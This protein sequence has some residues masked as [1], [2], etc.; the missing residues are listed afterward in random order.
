M[1]VA[2]HLS[3]FVSFLMAL[4]SLAVPAW[5]GPPEVTTLVS[6]RRV[7]AG[8]SFTLTLAISSDEPLRGVSGASFNAPTGVTASGPSTSTSTQTR[9]VNG[10]RSDR[11]SV[12]FTF[13]LTAQ[14]LGTITLP[15]PSAMHRGSRLVGQPT[16]IEVVPASGGSAGASG[17][18]LG[19]L[20]APVPGMMPQLFPP[21]APDF[22]D[23][24][25][26]DDSASA[27]ELAME[28]GPD[29]P[30]FLRAIPDKEKAYVG[31]QV[32]LSVY[33][34]YRVAYEMTERHDAKYKDFLRFPLLL[35][36]G[37]TTP[38]FTR[39]NGKRYGARLVDR[40]AVVPLRAGKLSTGSM[41]ARF[42]GRQIGA[43]VL[44]SSNDVVI[45]AV[46]PPE[47]GR[48]SGYTIGDVGKFTITAVVTP[49][50]VKQG[51]SVGVVLTVEG[52]GNVPSRLSP[53]QQKGVEWL[54]PR[55]R[56]AVAAKGGRIGGK[57]TFEY[58][59]RLTSAGN[60]DL[61]TVELPF[62]DPATSK[63]EVAKAVL[64]NVEVEEAAPT[65][66]EVDRAKKQPVGQDDPLSKLPA[67]HTSLASFAKQ[68]QR[69][70]SA[71]HLGAAFAAAPLLALLWMGL[72]RA[73]AAAKNR[74]DSGSE[75]RSKAKEAIAE[76]KKADASGEP[77]A[78][79]SAV[80][81]ALSLF[82]EAKTGIKVRGL[83]LVELPDRLIA[84]GVPTDVAEG[85]KS[86]LEECEGGRYVPSP[87]PDATRELVKRAAALGKKLGA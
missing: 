42:N 47:D 82:L 56:D 45:D 37:S 34:Y 19:V 81:R 66:A 69:T 3:V 5:A 26:D 52:I 49:R 36:P 30:V 58:V 32:T 18:S 87:D 75:L 55:V 1:R 70:F 68:T 74:K 40:V 46:E 16:T 35:D 67:P 29:E 39:V 78:V 65:Q 77:R 57:R 7:E 31:E 43:R 71:L 27:R 23:S 72:T 20:G 6:S 13:M 41:S 76:A 63:Y 84:A 2:L 24:A 54:A 9:I 10:I 25:P 22:D 85:A 50:K 44:K 15:A 60:T 11:S 83:R 14:A 86:L 12:R 79:F 59:V 4:V 28:T 62:F 80:E 51:G 53:P 17:S 33:L 73:R 21:P 8:E 64:G 61:G 38:V 48:P